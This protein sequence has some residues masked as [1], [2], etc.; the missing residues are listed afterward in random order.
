MPLQM[1]PIADWW[2][3]TYGV[4][5]IAFDTERVSL[6]LLEEHERALDRTYLTA[7]GCLLSRGQTVYTNCFDRCIPWVRR[8][9]L[10]R[11]GLPQ[12]EDFVWRASV[13]S[14]YDYWLIDHLLTGHFEAIDEI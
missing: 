8:D 7:M 4:L 10:R 5:L 11:L 13:L 6:H 14:A 12:M 9:M 1:N 3:H 2:L